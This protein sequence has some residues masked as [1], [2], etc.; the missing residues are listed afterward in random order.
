[1]ALFSRKETGDV[2]EG[3]DFERNTFGPYKNLSNVKP[4]FI[5]WP[6]TDSKENIQLRADYYD[7]L[8]ETERARALKFATEN[9]TTEQC[10]DLGKEV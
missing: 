2:V 9:D 6:E 4:I 10:E 7:S 3:K 5:Y 8:R 1:M